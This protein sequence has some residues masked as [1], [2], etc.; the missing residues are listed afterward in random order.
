M[1]AHGELVLDTLG[2]YGVDAGAVLR[3]PEWRTGVTVSMSMPKDRA[4][5]TYFGD[6]IDAKRGSPTCGEMIAQIADILRWEG[7]A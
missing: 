6:T 1:D 5:V 2:R 7:R 3:A 4:M